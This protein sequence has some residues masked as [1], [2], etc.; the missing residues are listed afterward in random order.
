MSIIF[1]I[2]SLVLLVFAMCSHSEEEAL[3]VIASGVFAIA[4]VLA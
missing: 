3:W 4:G 2:F 1:G